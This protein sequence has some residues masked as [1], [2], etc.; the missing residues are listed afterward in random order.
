MSCSARR[1]LPGFRRPP[2][3]PREP[4]KSARGATRVPKFGEIPP[5]ARPR[6]AERVRENSQPDGRDDFRGPNWGIFGAENCA[7]TTSQPVRA[8]PRNASKTR[9][10]AGPLPGARREPE[11]ACALAPVAAHRRAARS[12]IAAARESARNRPPTGPDFPFSL[13]SQFPLESA[14]ASARSYTSARFLVLTRGR[15][16]VHPQQ[17]LET[18]SSSRS[19]SHAATPQRASQFALESACESARSNASTRILVLARVRTQV[20]T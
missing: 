15:T 19:S 1:E 4:K 3:R 11:R 5:S 14:H 2:S 8:W 9:N 7:T 20:R 6:L 10:F 13:E 18:T 12:R 17:H 16:Q